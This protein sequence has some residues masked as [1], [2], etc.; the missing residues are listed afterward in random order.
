MEGFTV[1]TEAI[2]INVCLLVGML[3]GIMAWVRGK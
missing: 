1:T 3:K 2:V